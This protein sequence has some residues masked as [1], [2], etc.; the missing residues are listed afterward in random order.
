MSQNTPT[1]S[2]NTD[3]CPRCGYKST[4]LIAGNGVPDSSLSDEC[5]RCG[6]IK[7]KFRVRAAAQH[8]ENVAL[9]NINSNAVAGLADTSE[10]Q[11]VEEQAE[12]TKI[13]T[14]KDRFLA[15]I[16]TNCRVAVIVAIARLVIV[17][18][19]TIAYGDDMVTVFNSGYFRM[20]RIN[21]SAQAIIGLLTLA[22]FIAAF[23]YEYVRIPLIHSA[24][25][26]ELQRGIIIVDNNGN[27]AENFGLFLRRAIVLLIHNII[28][29]TALFP[30]IDKKQRTLSD[31]ASESHPIK[32]AQPT[33]NGF[34]A[35]F[36]AI[37]VILGTQKLVM[38][39]IDSFMPQSATERAKELRKEQA[40]E[41]AARRTIERMAETKIKNSIKKD[42]RALLDAYHRRFGHYTS[43]I[44]ML[45]ETCGSEVFGTRLSA[46]SANIL[47][48]QI[49]I[50]ADQNPP[51]IEVIGRIRHKARQPT[52]T[53]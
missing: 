14:L 47:D 43:D 29:I 10:S 49:V 52:R 11:I 42:I 25:R 4:P 15:Y 39:R 22:A 16:I 20:A 37:M 5:P 1:D 34:A 12:A 23:W 8:N 6:V 51:R 33:S 44:L 18:L 9:A 45:L 21:N 13:P 32:V 17:M 40:R 46:A 41:E 26:G 28:I 24:T 38:W 35:F 19:V 7:S 36:L 3:P 50:L 2:I 30:F 27:Q 31:L 48:N 53:R